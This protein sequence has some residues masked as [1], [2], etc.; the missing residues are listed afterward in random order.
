MRGSFDLHSFH[1]RP[2]QQNFSFQ[3]YR[4]QSWNEPVKIKD[5][6]QMEHFRVTEFPTNNNIHLKPFNTKPLPRPVPVLFTR[7]VLRFSWQTDMYT[8]VRKKVFL[9]FPT[10]GISER[11]YVV[12]QWAIHASNQ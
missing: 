11:S 2:R 10:L 12:I 3:L 4:D 9:I 7:P 1:Q 8:N 5:G 6:F